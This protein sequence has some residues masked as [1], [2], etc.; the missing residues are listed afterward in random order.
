MAGVL[1]KGDHV[2]EG[3]TEL[4]HVLKEKNK[5]IFFVTNNSTNSREMYVEKFK[6]KGFR[7]IKKE[8]ILT[9]AFAAARYL[10]INNFEGK[11]YVVG[12]QGIFIELQDE[13]IECVGDENTHQTF[14]AKPVTRGVIQPLE[15]ELAID[16]NESEIFFL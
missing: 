4:I 14:P 10:K 5:T 11:V 3:A 1:W 7:D 13:N 8:E 2:I 6:K 15:V 9:S 12:E 16:E